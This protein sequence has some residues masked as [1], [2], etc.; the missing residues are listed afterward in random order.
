VT[1]RAHDVRPVIFSPRCRVPCA[2]CD[3]VG[4]AL[5]AGAVALLTDPAG[6][7]R[8]A[9]AAAGVPTLVTEDPRALLGALAARIYG[10]PT[11]RLAVL[12]SPGPAARPLSPS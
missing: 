7:T 3:F 8:P 6:A 1:L 10:D 11:A 4:Q 9:V 5:A 2:R 12:G